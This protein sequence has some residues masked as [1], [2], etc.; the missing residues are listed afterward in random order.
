MGV[1]LLGYTKE[2]LEKVKGWDGFIAQDG[3]FYKVVEKGDMNDV[4]DIFTDIF[5]LNKLGINLQKLYE[6]F[7]EHRVEYRHIRYSNKDI[8]I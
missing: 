1:C 6:N 7:C 4:H 2:N 3:T 5:S 8:F